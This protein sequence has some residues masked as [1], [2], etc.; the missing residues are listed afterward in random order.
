[1]NKRP[2]FELRH[3]VRFLGNH[4]SA[5]VKIDVACVISNEKERHWPK[6]IFEKSLKE[7]SKRLQ[8]W[9]PMLRGNATRMAVTRF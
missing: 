9:E 5:V 2:G 3:G 4:S 6:T 7:F 8:K 1:M